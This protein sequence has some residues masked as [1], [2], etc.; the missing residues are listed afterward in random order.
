[1]DG[2]T[3]CSCF[4]FLIPLI[5]HNTLF[6][7]GKVVVENEVLEREDPNE[8]TFNGFTKVLIQCSCTCRINL[9]LQTIEAKAMYYTVQL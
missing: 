2:L 8:E 3:N 1:M 7:Q 5:K 4:W 9:Y 6:H